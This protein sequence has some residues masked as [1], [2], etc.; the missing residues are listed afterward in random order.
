MTSVV[1]RFM[2]G[3]ETYTVAESIDG[4]QLVEA[5]TGG[6]V[7]VA[8]VSSAAVVGVALKPAGLPVAHTSGT[9]LDVATAVGV[10]NTVPVV[11]GPAV[12]K[13][14]YA[15]TAAFGARLAA[16]ASGQVTG[17]STNPIVGWCAEPG[18]VTSGSYGLVKLT[19]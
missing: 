10:P 19:V 2:T 11:T 4:G 16:A 7:G 1:P 17:A 8:A 15:A 3:P 9:P 13:V 18:G 5:R 14:K 12:V 6:L